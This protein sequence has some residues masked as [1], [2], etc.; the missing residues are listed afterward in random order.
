D[1][2][3][4]SFD[5]PTS[6]TTPAT[7]ANVT[8]TTPAAVRV[9]PRR[10]RGVTG[11]RRQS[12]GAGPIATSAMGRR[13]RSLSHGFAR[14]A[15]S[16]LQKAPYDDG[17]LIEDVHGDGHREQRVRVLARCDHRREDHDGDDRRAPPLA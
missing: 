1:E 5:R 14:C 16:L 12:R 17:C 10:R 13:P 15:R 8:T 11:P 3:E 4:W 9:S 2:D 6:H 7:T